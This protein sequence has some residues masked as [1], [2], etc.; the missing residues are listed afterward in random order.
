MEDLLKG[1]DIKGSKPK[2]VLLETKAALSL[3][4]I[5]SKKY[6]F[7]LKMIN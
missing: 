5:S 1:F 3:N 4:S 2:A 7:S 6:S